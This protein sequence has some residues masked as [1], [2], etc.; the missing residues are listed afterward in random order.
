MARRT[1]GAVLGIV[2]IL[3]IPS[4][5]SASFHLMKITEIFAGKS[6]DLNAQYV[7]LQMYSGGQNLVMG[8][9]VTV[10]DAAGVVAGTFTFPTDVPSGNSQDYIL[11]A[12]AE[13]ETL[14]SISADLVITPALAA[15]GGKVCFEDIDCVS[16]GSFSGSSSSPSPSGTP[17][18]YPDGIQTGHAIRRDIS[19]GNASTLQEGDDTND[20]RDDFDCV[21]TAMPINNAGASGTYTDPVACPVCGDNIKQ[22]GEQCDGA[23]ATACPGGC[24]TSCVCPAHDS[25]VLPVKPVKVKIPDEAPVS[26]TKTVKV[27]VV[28][29]DVNEGGNDTIKLTAT[30][31][32]PVGVTVGTPD[33]GGAGDE[34]VVDAGRKATAAVAVT[35]TDAA[36]TTFNSKAPKRCTLTFTSTTTGTNPPGGGGNVAV[37]SNLDPTTSNNSTTAELNVFDENDTESSSPPHESF[38]V[39]LKPVKVKIAAGN[40]ASTK[41]TKPVVGN[42]DI[43]PAADTDDAINV[44]VDVSACPGPPT[45]ALDMNRDMAGDQSSTLVDGGR[46]GKGELLLTFDASAVTTGNAKSPQRCTAT[47]TATGPTDPD[48]DTTN[49]ATKLV[50]DILDKNDL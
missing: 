10:Y 30:S 20:S 46:T 43:V 4:V 6:G 38:A 49:N 8:H 7:M 35:V 37:V 33:F 24:L 18:G 47:I 28:N 12:T 16:W 23:D 19:H 9:T 36:F 29:A 50:I 14:F 13:A 21:N 31:N 45:V 32:C 3:A 27:K 40:T 25:V 17:F 48:P 5:S 42:A 15:A 26:V 11:L 41:K 44:T 2:G 34:T 22:S 39:S 1:R